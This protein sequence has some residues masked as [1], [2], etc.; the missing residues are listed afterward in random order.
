MLLKNRE[1]SPPDFY[2]YTHAETGHVSEAIDWHTWQEK[3]RSHRAGNNLPPIT[4]EQ[5]EEQLCQI[6][7]PGWCKHPDKERKT[8]R[9]INTRLRF[10]DI[11]DGTK[12]YVS[13]ILSGFQTVS[14]SEADR[15]AAICSG[16][17]LRVLPDGCAACVKLSRLI[18]GD[19]AR[20][21]T[22][23]DQHITNRA[24]AACGCHLAS[25]VHF[26][27]SALEKPQVDSPEKQERYPDFC[28]RK[29]DGVNYRP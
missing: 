21:T 5:A 25:V 1:K 26:P 16:C 20:K 17:F 23:Y 2:R 29:R 7:P 8:H 27:M 19:I 24:C 6:L 10:R 22:A 15:R 14:Q 12:A 9:W 11:A 18:T 3:I 28:W 13:L 4:P